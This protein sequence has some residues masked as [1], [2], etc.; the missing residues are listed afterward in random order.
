VT[1]THD[2]LNARRDVRQSMRAARRALPDIDRRTNQT[3][4]LSRLRS[5][6]VFRSSRLIG[7]YAAFDGEPDLEPLL[8]QEGKQFCVPVIHQ[9]AM[10]FARIDSDTIYTANDFGIAQPA[11]PEYVDPRRLDLVLTPLVAFDNRGVRIGVGRGYYDR[12]F[13]FLRTRRIW[14]RPKLLGIAF[15]LQRVSRLK[16][17]EWDIPLWGVV[18]EKSAQI[19]R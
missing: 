12:C 6:P 17:N 19:F 14:F 2:Q 1:E 8:A 3:A 16:P 18:T 9:A 7:T 11:A 15:S 13:S 10:A 4:L 5:L